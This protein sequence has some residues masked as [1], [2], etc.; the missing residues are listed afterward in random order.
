MPINL[1]ANITEYKNKLAI[2]RN[3]NLLFKLKHDISFFKE[4]TSNP[5]KNIVIMGK[6]TYFSIPENN[7][8]LNNRIN[9]VLT[10]N[11]STK[12]NTHNLTCDKPYFLTFDNF[13]K[14]YKKYSFF[15]VFV[16][17]GAQ[18]YNLFLSHQELFPTKLYITHVTNFHGKNIKFD[19]E[20][21]VFMNHFS[22]KYKLIGFSKQY[23][24]DNKKYKYRVLYYNYDNKGSE[25]YKYLDL[26]KDILYNGNLRRNR[27]GIDTM[28]K[29]GT[30]L[31]F[32]ISHSIPLVTCKRIPFNIIVNE[33]LWMLS[34]NSDNSILQE[35]NIHIW[36]GNSSRKFL[37]ER[38]LNHYPEGVLGPIYGFQWRHFGAKYSSSFANMSNVD[39]RLVG[40]FDQIAN[41]EKLLK[42][43]P[44]SRR[45]FLSA[46]NPG[47]SNEMAIDC[48][49]VSCQFYV[50]EKNNE[51]YLSC[52]F[53]MRS[54]DSLAWCYNIISYT[55][56]TLIFCKKCNMKPDKI[57]YI[58]GDCHVYT[59]HI[60][61]I[62][63][64]LKRESR[65]F[66]NVVLN[67]SI[68][69]KDYHEILDTDFSLVGYFP[70]ASLKMEMA[71]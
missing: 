6:K 18:I 39:R 51:K 13:I 48:C 14:F 49:H 37:D 35:K 27:T 67:D 28:S 65:P 53:Y 5:S 30:K 66:P 23:I 55:L 4:I 3:D 25:E 16:I 21:N 22:D 31:E 38:G 63:E 12:I 32:D 29:F 34:A 52:Q 10:N 62:N 24:T 33:L 60:L 15:N 64:Q 70:N 46:W 17:G 9:F 69:N 58:A 36:D 40:G 50:L 20:P 47:Q 42:T 41:I 19:I 59:N 2:G 61:A 71:I 8:P 68:I 44:F 43:D 54:S 45:I 1:V 57:F 26:I 7:R 56:L 11:S